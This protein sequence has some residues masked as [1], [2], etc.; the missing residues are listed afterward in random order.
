M[1]KAPALGLSAPEISLSAYPNPGTATNTIRYSV[2]GPSAM[3]ILVYD[4]N[5]KLVKV[6][7]DKKHDAGI[8]N[9]QWDMSK[10]SG[11]TYVVTAIKDGNVKQT[12]K[13]IKN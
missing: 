10:L 13:V 12:I 1:A 6:L 5:G 7:A 8:Y 11:G 3:K 9:I 2:N 4:M